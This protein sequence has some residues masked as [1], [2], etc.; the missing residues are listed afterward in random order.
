MVVNNVIK[1]PYV[2]GADKF[3]KENH[4]LYY[5]FIS[6]A[7]PQDE[8]IHICKKKLL[9]IYFKGIFGSPDSKYSHI[10]KIMSNY[11]ILKN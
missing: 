10:Q 4:K 3:I 8:M 7:T 5:Q 11:K 2:Y 1:A 9:D 6:T